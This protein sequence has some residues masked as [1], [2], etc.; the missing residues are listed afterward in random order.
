MKGEDRRLRLL[1]TLAAV[2]GGVLGG[3]V[4]DYARHLMWPMAFAEASANSQI[5]SAREFRVVDEDGKIRA[6][7]FMD[8]PYTPKLA[9]YDWHGGED[10]QVSLAAASIGGQLTLSYSQNRE[11]IP[12]QQ[13]G[14]LQ[15]WA[16]E[17][18]GSLKIGRKGPV[19]PPGVLTWD[20]SPEVHL[21]T[22]KFFTSLNLASAKDQKH[23]IQA[24]LSSSGQVFVLLRDRNGEQRAGL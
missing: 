18:G 17:N 23:A 6:R 11:Y 3:V 2:M 22:S 5:V 9:L 4:S 21:S 24:S 14:Q 15:L 16:E 1:Y 20:T 8:G 7:L 10:E 12:T 13:Q 19:G